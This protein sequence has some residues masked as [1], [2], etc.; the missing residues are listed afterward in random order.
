MIRTELAVCP[1]RQTRS[2]ACQLSAGVQSRSTKITRLARVKSDIDAIAARVKA[3]EDRAQR[4]GEAPGPPSPLVRDGAAL[5]RKLESIERMLWIPPKTPGIVDDSSVALSR[6]SR[7]ISSLGSSWDA[8]TPAQLEYLAE[9]E[10]LLEKGIAEVDRF[11]ATDLPA[12]QD[13]V[14][15]AEI[16]YLGP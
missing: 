14:R 9:A 12:Y 7:V 16:G 10:R 4:P 11:F 1:M 6:I 3:D 15:K 8:P 2:S 13:A 5:K